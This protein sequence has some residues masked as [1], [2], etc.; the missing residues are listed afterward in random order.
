M[1]DKTKTEA[2]GAG[3][4]VPQVNEIAGESYVAIPVAGPMAELPQFAP[5]KFPELH[6][7]MAETGI[8]HGGKAFFR[9][10]GFRP[11]GT[12]DIEVGATTLAPQ[13]GSKAVISGEIPAGN[14]ACATYTGPYDRLYDA[15]LMLNGWLRGRGLEPAALENR[16]GSQAGCQLEIYRISPANEADP[17]K[18]QTDLMIRLADQH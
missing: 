7:W 4:S 18:W 6:A 2:A 15:F 9:Y 13:E 1:L 16:E 12:A 11:D 3:L 14:Y 17:E 8:P 10:T 5:P